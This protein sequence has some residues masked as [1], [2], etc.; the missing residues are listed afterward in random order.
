MTA[1][2]LTKRRNKFIFVVLSSKARFPP[3]DKAKPNEQENTAG[4][5]NL[6]AVTAM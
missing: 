6:P 3:P 1:F 4:N 5:F 2:N